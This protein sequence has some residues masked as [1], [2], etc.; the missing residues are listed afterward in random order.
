[1]ERKY[2][3][4]RYQNLIVPSASYIGRTCQ[5][6]QSNRAGKSG[7]H[8]LVLPKFG[9]AIE[10]YGWSNF[11]YSVLEDGLTEEESYESRVCPM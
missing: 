1:M 6:Y 8:Y 3:V 5:K 2:R 10:T 9:P 7:S 4:Y 11:E